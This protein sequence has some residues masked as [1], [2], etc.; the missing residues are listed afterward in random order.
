MKILITG[1]NGYIGPVL[2]NEIK[3]KFPKSLVYGFDNNYFRKKN[4]SDIQ[5]NGDIRNF[6]KEIFKN[7]IDAVVH[8]ASL[9]ND[10]IGNKY[11]N[12]TK[13][14]NINAT[15]RLIDLSKKNGCKTFIFASSCS[16]YGK[17][18]D[19]SRDEKCKTQPLTGYA[20]SK[21]IIEDYLKKKTNKNFKSICLRFATACG[22]SSNLRL[23]LV[24]NDFVFSALTK[25][26]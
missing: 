6:P 13:Q 20:K 14:I 11:E 3:K 4:F 10:P 7:N 22:A 19:K 26:K 23:D 8:L 25:K 2:F 18:G 9:S 5:Y 12:Q 17:Y 16:V 21:I 24:L 15:K 1:N